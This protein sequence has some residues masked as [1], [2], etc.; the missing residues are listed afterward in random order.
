METSSTEQLLSEHAP[1]PFLIHIEPQMMPQAWP[2]IEPILA[3]ACAESA[4]EFTL[5]RILQSLEH[6]P[7][8]AIVR[9][10]DV[11]A[12]MVTCIS[13]RADGARVL[14]CLLASGDHA[15]DWPLVD[16]EFDDFARG[17]GCVAVRIPRARKGWL[18][19]LPHW[20]LTGQFVTLEREI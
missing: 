7:I 11:Q 19:A 1:A 10:A 15:S 14:D 5:N 4:G 16:D 3:K 6:W 13:I 18:K 20:K 9:G 8:L 17:F 12:V 2:V